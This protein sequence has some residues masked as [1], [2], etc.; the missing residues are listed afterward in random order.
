MHLGDGYGIHGTNQPEL[1]GQMVS[2]G[3]IRMYNKDVEQLYDQVALGTPVH[4]VA[5]LPGEIG[6]PLT[7]TDRAPSWGYAPSPGEKVAGAKQT[8]T[9]TVVPGDS[10]WLI[11]QRFGTSVDELVR[12]NDIANPDQIEVGRTLAVPQN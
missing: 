6:R 12:L 1:I 2:H 7:P 3:C 9:Y 11:A 10:L 8:G 4:I 5:S